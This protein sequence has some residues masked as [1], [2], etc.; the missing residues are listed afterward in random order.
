MKALAPQY[1]ENK[2]VGVASLWVSGYNRTFLALR[3]D[4]EIDGQRHINPYASSYFSYF[5]LILQQSVPKRLPP[6]FSRGLAA[7]MS[8][9]VIDDAKILLGPPAPWYLQTLHDGGRSTLA[10]LVKADTRSPLLKGDNQRMFDAQAW[11]L[12]HYLM[13]AD[14]GAHWASLNRYSGMVAGG[15]DPD[16]A[17]RE[18]LGRPEDLEAP[19][20]FYM[21]RSI[22]SFRAIGVDASVAREK[23][24]VTVLSPAE[25]AGRRAMFHVTMHRPVEARAAIAETRKAGGSPDADVAEGLLLDSE[26][27]DD[28]AR[29]ALTRATDAG[30]T[31]AYAYY[32]LASLLWR[33]DADHA[34]LERLQTLL[35]KSV[36]LNV[37][38][39]AAYDFLASI[40]GQLGVAGASG[41]A[42]RA[43]S[44][45]PDD[46]HHHLTAARL[47]AR[48][49]RYDEALTHV[50]AAQ[51]LAEDEAVTRE[52]AE[53][54]TWIAQM[55]SRG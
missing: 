5:S 28:E 13:F 14:N 8:N 53:A 40:N 23:F 18:A 15:A 19:V 55:K 12:V 47:L 16:V 26:H 2:N 36:D 41:L 43:I 49:K 34:T 46:A 27:K 38:Y 17:F 9:T 32:R 21:D 29:A 24:A 44:L 35:S 51:D 6:W 20:R 45:E 25:S 1:W 33:A 10:D 30:T 52:V 50:Q 7:V 48:E 3:T 11:A 54:R 39:A 31:D 37:R 22:Y 4:V 42:L